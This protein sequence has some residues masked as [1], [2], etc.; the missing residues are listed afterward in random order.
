M[1]PLPPIVGGLAAEKLDPRMFRGSLLDNSPG[2]GRAG[3]FRL[4]L[5]ATCDRLRSD[6]IRPRR[7]ELRLLMDGRLDRS[8]ALM[9]AAAAR[10]T[11]D[12]RGDG[13]CCLFG[14]DAAACMALGCIGDEDIDRDGG[15][16]F[17]SG[18]AMI[19]GVG[20]EVRSKYHGR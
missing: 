12:A 3:S 8:A 18:G 9:L 11:E 16:E 7:G 13:V 2:L 20:A 15:R 14:G 5:I 6:E 4:R 19:L 1:V 17:R 10:D